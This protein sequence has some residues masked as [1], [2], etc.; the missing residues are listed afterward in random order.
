M[1][2]IQIILLLLSQTV[3]SQCLIKFST[4]LHTMAIK[5]DGSLWAWGLNTSGQLGDGTNINK[6]L[7]IQVGNDTNWSILSSKFNHC[8]AIKSNG[9]LWA[10]GNNL[11]GQLGNSF[12][13]GTVNIPFQIGNST[14]ISVSAG[15]SYSLGI[16]SNGTL[17]AWGGN[18]DGQLGDGTITQ[19]NSPVQIG[20]SSNW[21]K[22]D[23]SWNHSIALKQDGTL[24]AW[25]N[26]NYGQLGDGTN[27]GKIIPTQ[28]GNANNWTQINAG[29]YFS[30]AL[31]SDGTLWSWGYNG[32]GRLGD[33]TSIISRNLPVQIGTSTNWTSISTSL[34][35]CIARRSDGTLWAWGSNSYG[36]LGNGSNGSTNDVYSPIL[37]DNSSGYGDILSAGSNFSVAVKNNGE[38]RSWGGNS[39]G[40]LGDGTNIDK[41]I[42]TPIICPNS[43]GIFIENNDVVNLHPNPFKEKLFIKTNFLVKEMTIF[44]LLGQVC[45]SNS[46]NFYENFFD[47]SMLKSGNYILKLETENTQNSYKIIKE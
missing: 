37:I 20:T 8:L 42:P 33:G 27:I 46:Q 6:N 34:G 23:C 1:K 13:G 12:S 30:I 18:E 38:I 47:L 44:N 21:I 31:K 24:W 9:T 3:F 36:Q 19:R 41:N 39:W 35:H 25:G 29:Q 2:K 22:V 15:T 17:W 45:Y 11:K 28:I 43:L 32:N 5:N 40:Q 16:K 26:N 14:W 4:S 7:P 10:W